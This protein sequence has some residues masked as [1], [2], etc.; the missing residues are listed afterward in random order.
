MIGNRPVLIFDTSVYNRMLRDGV[1]SDDIMAALRAAYFVRI[2]GLSIEEVCAT[3]D[4][5][6]RNAIMEWVNKSQAGPGDYLLP[7]NE[8]LRLLIAAYERRPLRFDW[9]AVNVS[10]V[11]CGQE[12]ARGNFI[13]DDALAEAQFQSL[14]HSKEEFEG[15]WSHLR[16]KLRDVI[17]RHGRTAPIRFQEV[18]PM[19]EAGGGLLWSFG[20]GLYSRVALGDA[21]E[22]TVRDF[23]A[24][25]PPFRAI[26][27]AYLLA[28]FDR[29]LADRHKREKYAAG[30]I[31]L[32]MAIYLPYCDQFISAEDRG[33]QEKCLREIARA[34]HLSTVVR[35]YDDFCNSMM[36]K[37]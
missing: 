21:S 20:Q 34:A 1:P 25:C 30:R 4:A 26:A 9:R 23:M 37:V 31:D 5:S 2:P 6:K 29:S 19:V 3:R 10:S 7:Q 12:I 33:M 14:R 18:L 35:S 8:I 24:K 17:Q 28:W 13:N 11:G 16:P 32:F 27:Y 15:V 36:L 22:P